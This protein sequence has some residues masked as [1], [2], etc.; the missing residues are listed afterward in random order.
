M[1][2]LNKL[3]DGPTEVPAPN[4]YTGSA[5]PLPLCTVPLPVVAKHPTALPLAEIPVGTCPPVHSVGVE[6]KEAAADAVA[7]LPVNGPTNDVAVT[8]VAFTVLGVV[9]PIGPGE[10]IEPEFKAPEMVTL[11][12]ATGSGVVLPYPAVGGVAKALMTV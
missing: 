8:V 7:A 4:P 2:S 5:Y 10:G 1:S 6:A 11:V 3:G 9:P 12:A